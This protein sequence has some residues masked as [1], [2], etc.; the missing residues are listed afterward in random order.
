MV[1]RIDSGKPVYALQVVEGHSDLIRTILS[2]VD[3]EVEGGLRN[4]KTFD[5]FFFKVEVVLDWVYGATRL[6]L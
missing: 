6:A 1:V 4:L 2:F 5:F 3:S